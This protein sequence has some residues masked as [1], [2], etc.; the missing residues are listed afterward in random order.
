V[1]AALAVD[2]RLMSLTGQALHVVDLARRYGVDI[3]D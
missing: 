2:P 3:T 1:I